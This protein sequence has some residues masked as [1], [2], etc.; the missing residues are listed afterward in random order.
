M[1]FLFP[2][3]AS[4]T[5]IFIFFFFFLFFFFFFYSNSSSTAMLLKLL[6]IL[7]LLLECLSSSVPHRSNSLV[8]IENGFTEWLNHMASFKHSLEKKSKK[9]K[10]VKPC[11][12]VKV[13]TKNKAGAFRSVQKA[14]NSVPIVN[15][16][17]VVIT[18]SA[19][20]YRSG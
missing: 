12:I 19:G 5:T 3:A 10:K 4:K 13:S 9:K 6:I 8:E 17:R 18:V 7:T 2:L 1:F 14:I 20:T 11:K 16:C 15:N